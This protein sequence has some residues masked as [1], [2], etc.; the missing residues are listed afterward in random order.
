MVVRDEDARQ[1]LEGESHDLEET[2]FVLFLR[3]FVKHRGRLALLAIGLVA[4]VA[5]GVGW[6]PG[7]LISKGGQHSLLQKW[8]PTR[9]E[10][11]LPFDRWM[12][13]WHVKPGKL[14]QTQY[15]T[16]SHHPY[17]LKA[18]E[19]RKELVRW[20]LAHDCP[21][22]VVNS[23]IVNGKVKQYATLEVETAGECQRACTETS[24]CS[25]WTWARQGRWARHCWRKQVGDDYHFVHNGDVVAGRPCA[26]EGRWSFWWPE[27]HEDLYELQV[28][29]MEAE[30]EPVHCTEDLRRGTCSST[31]DRSFLPWPLSEVVHDKPDLKCCAP[32]EAGQASACGDGLVP[33]RTGEAC[34][35]FEAADFGCCPPE[36]KRG[37]EDSSMHCIVLFQAFSKEQ[38]LLEMQYHLN[39]GIFQ[40]ES[41][42]LYSNQRVEILPGLVARQIH[43]TMMCELGG[44]FITALNLGI[45][46]A[47]YR[48]V[49]ADIEFM[50]TG[51][52][53]KVDPDTV[54]SAN[55]LRPMLAQHSWGVGGEGI[56]LN[57]CADGLHGPIEVF[58]QNAFLTL[59]RAAK[60]CGDALDGPVCT[61]NCEQEWQ[62]TR[63]CNGRCT[64]WWGE[65][66]WT[67]QCLSRFTKAKRV[68]VKTLLQED[69][70]KPHIPDWRSCNDDK[71]V[72]FHPFKDPDE[73]RLCWERMKA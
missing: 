1:L 57:N 65:D 3:H 61:E 64:D 62:Q 42:A 51:W 60:K 28:P 16:Y 24:G 18:K 19:R 35:G 63:Q 7:M 31:L 72:A 56:Y 20:Q 6:R 53:V 71:T 25:G 50:Q 38:E 52:V 15:H 5:F 13:E 43:S 41:Y 45:F 47:L 2:R 26:S 12:V 44:Q 27:H 32:V 30:I 69:H 73:F 70:C 8:L 10:E 58:S 46:L 4:V 37:K 36:S 59:G 23:D 21:K 14:T 34:A 9:P 55:R 67:D 54:W 66:I 68:M 22:Q 29:D 49:L 11:V 33:V 39:A 17:F 40:C 48:Q